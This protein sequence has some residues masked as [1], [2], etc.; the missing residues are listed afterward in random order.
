M[1][2]QTTADNSLTY[3]GSIPTLI[4]FKLGRVYTDS[5][6]INK[7]VEVPLFPRV[8]CLMINH[9]KSLLQQLNILSLFVYILLQFGVINNSS[10]LTACLL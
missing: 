5:N 6:I 3:G 1:N 4:W 10:T 9:Q 7:L 2:V 8:T